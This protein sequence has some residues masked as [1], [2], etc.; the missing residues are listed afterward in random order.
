MNTNCY[1]KL[2]HMST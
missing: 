2:H 1:N